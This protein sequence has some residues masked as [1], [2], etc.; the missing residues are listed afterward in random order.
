MRAWLTFGATVLLAAA[1]QAHQTRS[2]PTHSVEE[3]LTGELTPGTVGSLVEHVRRPDVIRRLDAALRHTRP[4]V[5]AV[6]ARVALVVGAHGLKPTLASMLAVE[7]NAATAAEMT[8]ALATFDAATGDAA[9]IEVWERLGRAGAAAPAVAFAVA[10]GASA[11]ESL[12]RLRAIDESESTLSAFIRASQPAPAQLLGLVDRAIDAS[13]ALTF[14]AALAVIGIRDIDIPDAALIRALEPLRPPD[15]RGRAARQILGR[16][17]D[18]PLAPSLTAALA[19]DGAFSTAG[20]EEGLVLRE[21]AGRAAGRPPTTS[22]EW[23]ARF[24]EPDRAVAEVVM[25]PRVRGLLTERERRELDRALPGFRRPPSPVPASPAAG[26]ATEPI[27]HLLDPYPAGFVPD[28]M[29]T[30]GCDLAKAKTQGLGA[31]AAELRLHPDG[32]VARVSLMNTGVS[33]PG[34]LQALR[35]LFMTH[36]TRDRPTADSAWIAV[37]PFDDEYVACRETQSRDAFGQPAEAGG[38]LTPPKKI[39]HVD[40]VYPATAIDSRVQGAVLLEATIGTR[41]CVSDLQ[42]RSGVDPRLD[43]SALLSVLKWRYTP[44]TIGGVTVPVSMTVT[45][46]FTLR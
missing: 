6:A 17:G 9:L 30:T 34:C 16:R 28:L 14:H 27:V 19:A 37:A 10:R 7:A 40:P 15:M 44:T 45:V 20:D 38:R 22:R 24:D 32:R 43:L 33:Q 11:L 23:L 35:V 3:L 42:V 31:G 18:G 2:S 8:R 36:V 21:F 12:S 29:A 46:Q 25:L 5:R 39:R 4:D 13:D 41:G 1:G 26:G